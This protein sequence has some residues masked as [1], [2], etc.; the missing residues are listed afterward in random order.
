MQDLHNSQS[1]QFNKFFGYS[2][3]LSFN[4]N[5]LNAFIIILLGRMYNTLT[6]G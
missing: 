5:L 6:V 4:E 2:T 1:T 3:K